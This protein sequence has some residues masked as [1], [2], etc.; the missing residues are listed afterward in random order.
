MFLTERGVFCSEGG[1]SAGW[2]WWG[3]R[4]D[5]AGGF[6]FGECASPFISDF[7]LQ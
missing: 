4:V 5:A 6:V 1:A 7:V 3:L 2:G